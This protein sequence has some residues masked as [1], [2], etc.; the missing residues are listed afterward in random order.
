MCPLKKV[1]L[2]I[3]CIGLVLVSKI[4]S[5][6]KIFGRKANVNQGQILKV[7]FKKHKENRISCWHF[8]NLFLLHWSFL[9]AVI[10]VINFCFSFWEIITKKHFG[11]FLRVALINGNK[12]TL[13]MCVFWYLTFR[14]CWNMFFFLITQILCLE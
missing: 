2:I 10:Y 7:I 3:C 5:R 14:H 6:S 13:W 8:Q 4:V 11:C 1:F 12:M 9:V